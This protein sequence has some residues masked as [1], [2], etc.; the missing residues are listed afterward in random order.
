M[1]E[2]IYFFWENL[3][4]KGMG[5]DGM[6]GKNRGEADWHFDTHFFFSNKSKTL[7]K[8]LNRPRVHAGTLESK[9]T[10]GF[11]TP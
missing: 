5:W 6:G 9:S 1:T 3:S 2:P 11:S 4:G 8:K 7:K 10:P